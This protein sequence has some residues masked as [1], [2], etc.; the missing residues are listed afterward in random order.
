V[1]QNEDLKILGGI[2]A[3]RKASSWVERHSIR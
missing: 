2:A 3:A 1:A